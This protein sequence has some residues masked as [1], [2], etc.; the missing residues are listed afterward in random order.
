M[1]NSPCQPTAP[2]CRPFIVRWC[3]A[4]LGGCFRR[5]AIG[6]AVDGEKLVEICPRATDSSGRPEL[7]AESR[8]RFTLLG[9]TKEADQNKL[10][11]K[12]NRLR[13]QEL[14]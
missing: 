5:Y 7:T 9:L 11:G 4:S 3:G 2:V 14:Q 12:V 6:E 8:R 10:V 13:R 1:S